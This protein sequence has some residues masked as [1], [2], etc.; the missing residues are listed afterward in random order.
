MRPRRQFTTEYKKECIDLIMVHGY[1][2][3]KAS[4]TMDVGM[5]SL[6]R[7][8]RQYRQELKGVTPVGAKAL[9][10]DQRKIQELEAK[11]RQL[12]REKEI[13]KKASAFFAMEMNNDVKLR[14]S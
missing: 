2:I 14:K 1:T 6:I 7:W 4:E 5:S 8:L 12:E 3:K 10:E 11:V 9:T 13:L